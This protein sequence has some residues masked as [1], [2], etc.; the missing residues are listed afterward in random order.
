M[1]FSKGNIIDFLVNLI[2]ILQLKLIKPL[3]ISFAFIYLGC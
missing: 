2:W 3:M 1:R